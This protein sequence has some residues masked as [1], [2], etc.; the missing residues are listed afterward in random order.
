MLHHDGFVIAFYLRYQIPWG[1]VYL[2]TIAFFVIDVG[3]QFKV[4][5]LA[6]CQLLGMTLLGAMCNMFFQRGLSFVCL[7]SS[8]CMVKSSYCSVDVEAIVIR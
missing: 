1:I 8:F 3:R 2:R 7:I 4:T 5:P 6:Y